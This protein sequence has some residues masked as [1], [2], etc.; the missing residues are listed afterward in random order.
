MRHNLSLN[1][2]FIKLP[3]A[4]GRPGKGHYWT[5]DPSQEYM[6]EDGGSF[7]RRP[8]GFRKRPNMK[9]SGRFDPHQPGPPS[10]VSGLVTTDCGSFATEAGPGGVP[11]RSGRGSAQMRYTPYDVPTGVLSPPPDYGSILPTTN[12]SGNNVTGPPPYYYSAPPSAAA[13]GYNF[14]YA[15]TP[16]SPTV[17]G[18]VAEYS[19]VQ[20]TREGCYNMV[21]HFPPNSSAAG[22]ANGHL[23]LVTPPQNHQDSNEATPTSMHE[24]WQASAWIP[25]TACSNMVE[26]QHYTTM[27]GGFASPSEAELALAGQGKPNLK[28]NKIHD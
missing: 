5:V 7:R 4:L 24:G 19:Y 3:K 25:T 9:G 10:N 16:I 21:Y 13:A 15:S 11:S 17:G 12:P 18:N 26:A 27:N 6:F 20:D 23:S 1:E 8:R 2:C 14:N 28:I 22:I